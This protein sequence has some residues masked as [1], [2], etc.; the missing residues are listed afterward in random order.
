MNS[1]QPSKKNWSKGRLKGQNRLRLVVFGFSICFA[2]IAGR[3]VELSLVRS[4]FSDK[5]AK[6]AH[7]DRIPR[8]D[9]VD[10]NGMLLATDIKVS[11]LFAN[12][13]KI[14]DVDE[15]VELLT[16][17]LPELDTQKL[18]K[19]LRNRKRAFVWIKREISPSKRAELYDLGI[20]GVQ[21]RRE[22]LRVYPNGPLGAH[23]LG[24]VDVDSRGIA[25]IE[26]YLDDQGALYTASLADPEKRAAFPAVLAMDGRVQHAMADEIGKAVEKFRAKAGAGIVM[27]VHTGEIISMVSLPD[28]DPNNP[29]SAQNAESINRIT[30]GVYELGSVIKAV[31]FAMAFDAGVMNMNS[32]FDATRPLVVGR[33]RIHDFHA[34]KRVLNVEEVFRYSS[35]IGTARM[36]LA[37]GIENHKAFLRRAGF[38]DRLVAELPEAAA[39]IIPKRWGKLTTVTAAFGH[40]FA[41]Q[42]MQG[43]AVTAALMNGGRLIPPTFLKRSP[44]AAQGLSRRLVSEDTSKKMRY[45]FRVNGTNGTARKANKLALGYRIGGKTGTAEKVVKGRYRADK[46]LN[47]FVGAFPMENPKFAVLIMLDEPQAVKGTYGYATSGWNAV[48][49]A[50][51]VVA[52]IAPLLGVAPE[53]TDAERAQIEKAASKT[54]S[55][56]KVH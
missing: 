14:I 47:S 16:A 49:T 8:P 15:A 33:A 2:V 1:A 26:K 56:S 13:R 20:P 37:V 41:I 3:L 28:Y 11:S 44:E 34:Q 25:G 6:V 36:A 53:F 46:R 5:T 31:T 43:L 23:I 4:Y 42:P 9:I 29:K 48:P 10:R 24:Y 17:V 55:K 19:K 21:F 39:P 18:D 40:G 7:Q 54:T 38:F 52:R 45:L 30:T 35:N 12:P 32:R 22:T 27:N 51:A 50:G